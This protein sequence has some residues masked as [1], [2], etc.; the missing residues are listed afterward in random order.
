MLACCL[1]A[2][3]RFGERLI[4]RTC[5]LDGRLG[6]CGILE[7]RDIG[8]V[9]DDGEDLFPFSSNDEVDLFDSFG[10]EANVRGGCLV[11]EF[12]LPIVTFLVTSSLRVL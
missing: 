6:D 4:E 3:H 8:L 11:E 5:L 10:D 12:A 2:C 1:D 9:I 7:G